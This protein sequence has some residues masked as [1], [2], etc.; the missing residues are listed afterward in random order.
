MNYGNTAH[1]KKYP[2]IAELVTKELL[3]VDMS[4]DELCFALNTPVCRYLGICGCMKK[5]IDEIDL[6]P[7]SAL[8]NL[9]SVS[10]YNNPNLK[11]LVIPE[12]KNITCLASLDNPSLTRV[13]LRNLTGFKEIHIKQVKGVSLEM[14]LE[15][16]TL[17]ES[18]ILM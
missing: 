12:L 7:L 2:K 13:D 17:L 10:L 8:T 4:K 3:E 11:T 18:V 16:P 14:Q 9:S 1:F 6:S 5:E 15:N